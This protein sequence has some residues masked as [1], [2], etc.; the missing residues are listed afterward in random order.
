MH[1]KA[2]LMKQLEQ[3]GT[4][5][6]G[7]LLVHSSLKSMGQL[8]QG[9]DTV[10]DA[11]S[12]YMQDGLLVLPTHTWANI[13]A[14][15]PKFHVDDSPSCIGILPE[16]FRK[17]QGVVRSWHPTHSV[18]AL[19]ADAPA[20]TSGD[21]R[22]DTPCAR[23]SVWGKLLDKQAAILLIGVDL[24]RNTFMHGVEEWAD[25]PGRIADEPELL[26]T[27]LPDGTEIPVPSRR[28]CGKNWSEHFWKVEG[29]FEERGVMYKGTLGDAEARVCASA[30]MTELL[31]EM[32][33]EFP[34]LFSDNE[35]LSAEFSSRF[36]V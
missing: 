24:R 18:A 30:G 4:D 27:V 2:S 31:L 10:L 34:D 3:L 6:Y 7:T 22:C 25:I 29:V 33:R 16:L 19:G 11:L 36:S 28:H 17:R 35:P 32:L 20:F 13:N 12:E 21:E 14:D 8:E 1:T 15:N 5:R 9:A 26:Y 23:E